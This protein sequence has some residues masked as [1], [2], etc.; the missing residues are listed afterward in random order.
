[1]KPAYERSL[2]SA[3]YSFARYLLRVTSQA[4][5]HSLYM[6]LG[7]VMPRRENGHTQTNE[8]SSEDGCDE[9]ESAYEDYFMYPSNPAN[10]PKGYRQFGHAYEQY[11]LFL[12]LLLEAKTEI[13]RVSSHLDYLYATVHRLGTACGIE[14]SS[15]LMHH[16]LFYHIVLNDLALQVRL[17]SFARRKPLTS[18]TRDC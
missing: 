6:S 10:C 3:P 11:V 9:D 18:P 1:M 17:L 7:A 13:D 5:R 14:L 15:H 2:P 16:A 4:L 12:L 8:E